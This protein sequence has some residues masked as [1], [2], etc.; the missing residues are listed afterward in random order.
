M[1]YFDRF[2]AAGEAVDE[3]SFQLAAI[4]TL[5]LAAKLHSR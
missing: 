5:Y 1:N 4:S 2:L 3:P